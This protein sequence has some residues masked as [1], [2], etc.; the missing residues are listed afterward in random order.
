MISVSFLGIKE[1]L[2]EQLLQLEKTDVSYFHCDIM[3]GKFVSQKTWN[4]EELLFLKEMQKPLDVHLMVEDVESYI[5]SFSKLNPTFITFHV[6]AT[7]NPEKMIRKI[8][9]Y[10]IKAGIS[11]KPDT[12]VSRINSYLKDID[13]VLVM[14]VEPG[15]GGQAFLPNSIEKIKTLKKLQKDYEY[16]IEVDGGVN[17]QT[18]Q[19]CKE[20]GANLFVV[21]SFITNH[22]NYQKQLSL[23]QIKLK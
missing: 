1:Q 14:S 22:S 23:L 8:H 9:S 5:E 11:I 2:K 12:P 21:G 6:E 16:V 7:K 19:I 3:D 15:K 4:V 17:D 20:S 13:L 18:I 10:G